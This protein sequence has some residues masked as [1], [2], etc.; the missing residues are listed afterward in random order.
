MTS[1]TF[2][3]GIDLGGTRFGAVVLDGGAGVG[4]VFGAFLALQAHTPLCKE[5]TSRAKRCKETFFAATPC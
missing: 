5:T 4:E 2:P 1:A 3:W